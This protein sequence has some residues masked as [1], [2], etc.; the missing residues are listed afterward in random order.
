MSYLYDFTGRWGKTLYESIDEYQHG[1]V[2]DEMC[3]NE[4]NYEIDAAKPEGE[5]RYEFV[6]FFMER[7][8]GGQINEIAEMTGLL[9]DDE[10]L[11]MFNEYANIPIEK[12][13]FDWLLTSKC[14]DDIEDEE[15]VIEEKWACWDH[16][17]ETVQ[18]WFDDI[19]KEDDFEVAVFMGYINFP[20]YDHDKKCYVETPG[21]MSIEFLDKKNTLEDKIYKCRRFK[22]KTSKKKHRLEAQL[23]ELKQSMIYVSGAESGYHGAEREFDS[24]D[25]NSMP[26]CPACEDVVPPSALDEDNKSTIDNFRDESDTEEDFTLELVASAGTNAY[27]IC[28]PECGDSSIEIV[29][30][31]LKDCGIDIP[32]SEKIQGAITA[33]EVAEAMAEAA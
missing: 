25:M 28:C 1:K 26:K 9:F 27:L 22:N 19:G 15:S 4:H 11:P 12:R 33:R 18:M 8:T 14:P 3:Y 10:T 20:K 30:M 29:E 5:R 23:L 6:E 17:S 32:E 13:V 16:I 24:V 2:W 31:Y 7:L 21:G